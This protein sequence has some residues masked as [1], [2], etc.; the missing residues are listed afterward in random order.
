MR[1]RNTARDIDWEQIEQRE[2]TESVS[3][4]WGD[5]LP[6]AVAAATV[7][8]VS[9]WYLGCNGMVLKARDGTTVFVD[10]YFGTGKPPRT[11]RMIP[12]PMDPR[13]VAAADAVFVTHEHSDHVHG[14]SQAPI[15]ADTGATFYGPEDSVS[16]TVE[17]GW[18]DRWQCDPEQFRTVT[19]GDRLEI[20]SLTVHVESAHDPLA[21]QPVSYAFEH[22][23]GTFFHGGDTRHDEEILS[24]IGQRHDIDVGVVAFG[25][26]GLI[27]DKET[28]ELRYRDWYCDGNEA[29]AVAEA[30]GIERLVPTHWDMWKGLRAEP[31]ALFHHARTFEH[32]SDVEVVEIGDRIEL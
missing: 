6:N 23:A 20:G 15:L 5:W 28:G 10:P 13:D 22:D 27:E 14:P 19:A 29:I 12:V 1:R 24:P 2:R 9:L 17:E 21:T 11:T 7:D 25:S 8:G 4:D 32:P 31:T 26:S 18:T 16:R 3:S 30:L